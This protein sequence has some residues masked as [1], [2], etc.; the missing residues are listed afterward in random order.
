[1]WGEDAPEVG[2]GRTAPGAGSH[3]GTDG[4]GSSRG[5]MAVPRGNRRVV[6]M[7]GYK[8]SVP[9][10]EIRSFLQELNT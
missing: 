8:E 5:R 6:W 9:D 7:G 4:C 3:R 10:L 1:M 2:L